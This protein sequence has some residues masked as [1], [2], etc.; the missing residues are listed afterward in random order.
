MSEGDLRRLVIPRKDLWSLVA[1]SAPALTRSLRQVIYAII[2][3]TLNTYR[4]ASINQ[5]PKPIN[6]VKAGR[7]S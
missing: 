2:S 5:S 3:L 1:V 7:T 6:H 4:L